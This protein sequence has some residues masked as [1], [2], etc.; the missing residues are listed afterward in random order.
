MKANTLKRSGPAPK[1]K[2]IFSERFGQ[3]LRRFGFW[4]DILHQY[5]IDW[6]DILTYVKPCQFTQLVSDMEEKIVFII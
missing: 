5:F 1:T 2:R 3:F 4:L 6:S